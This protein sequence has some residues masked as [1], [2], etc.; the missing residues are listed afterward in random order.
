MPRSIGTC[1]SGRV[2]QPAVPATVR[3]SILGERYTR[4]SRSHGKARGAAPRPAPP[5]ARCRDES[6]SRAAGRR[7]RPCTM[8]CDNGTPLCGH[9]VAQREH[10]VVACG[11]RQCRPRRCAPRAHPGGGMSSSVPTSIQS[12]IRICLRLSSAE[13]S[14]RTQAICFS[15]M[16]SCRSAPL[17]RAA[18]GSTW[19]NV[20]EYQERSASFLRPAASSATLCFTYVSPTR[21]THG[22][23]RRGSAPLRGRL[24]GR[25]R[26][27]PSHL[28]RGFYRA[29][30]VG[31][32][33][34][35]AAVAADV[36]FVTRVHA[37][38]AEVLDGRL[39]AVARAARHRELE[40]VRRPE[41][42]VVFSSSI[43]RAVESWVPKRHQVL[44]TQVLTVRIA[45]P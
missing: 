9:L 14:L 10:L 24:A 43:P 7:R 1:E 2:R 20:C 27:T 19:A 15:G 28:L 38:H 37:H 13:S 12:F 11:T 16:N 34:F 32:A 30:K 41:P 45:L 40:L 44:P 39:G 25:R 6:S 21:S 5:P 33:H 42:Q 17:A 26:N 8:P 31:D 4:P 36:Q 18:Q 23:V 29:Q 3:D 22:A 35:H